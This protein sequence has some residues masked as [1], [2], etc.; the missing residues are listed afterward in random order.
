MDPLTLL[1]I[2]QVALAAGSTVYNWAAGNSQIDQQKNRLA[3]QRSTQIGNLDVQRAQGLQDIGQ[4]AGTQVASLAQRGIVG[5]P[6]QLQT[7]MTQTK[8]TARLGTWYDQNLS[9]INTAA[10]NALS[11][12]TDQQAG[13]NVNALLGLTG[14]GLSGAGAIVKSL[15]LST[16]VAGDN[17][18]LNLI[19]SKGKGPFRFEL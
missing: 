3:Q 18:G 15:P 17:T 14:I 4:A 8:N 7:D 19:Q 11:D 13:L 16:P 2:S 12:L 9:A 10:D 1:A 5:D 6:A